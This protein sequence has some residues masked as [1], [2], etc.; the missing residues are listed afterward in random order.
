VEVP[1]E[2]IVEVEKIVEIHVDHR[3]EVDKYKGLLA[4]LQVIY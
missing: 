3:E 1:V 4:R 2:V